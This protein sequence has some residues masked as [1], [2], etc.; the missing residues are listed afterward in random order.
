MKNILKIYSMD[1]LLILLVWA[2]TTL[3]SFRE[4]FYMSSITQFLKII[5]ESLYITILPI[6]VFI[7]LA[8]VVSWIS[9]MLFF[10]PIIKKRILV[11]MYIQGAI[12]T[13]II[14][15]LTI[16][17]VFRKVF[18]NDN[19]KVSDYSIIDIIQ[20]LWHGI[21]SGLQSIIPI[22]FIAY[23]VFLTIKYFLIL[24]V[25]RTTNN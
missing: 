23:F 4:F 10:I 25:L 5:G 6:G 7:I 11:I 17:N 24:K 13:I 8:L 20:L 16:H 18:E 19:L 22:F 1:F 12:V 15:S 9:N 2:V 3:S 21:G 14:L